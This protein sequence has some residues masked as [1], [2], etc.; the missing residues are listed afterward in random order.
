[1]AARLSAVSG[2][3]VKPPSGAQHESP[4]RD[5]CT[6]HRNCECLHVCFLLV[7]A[8]VHSSALKHTP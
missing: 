2:S 5:M 6:R 1:M 3:A 4:G 8:R 7:P